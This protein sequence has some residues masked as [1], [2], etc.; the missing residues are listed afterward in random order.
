M[1]RDAWQH[2]VSKASWLETPSVAKLA[3][4]TPE[5]PTKLALAH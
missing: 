1:A 3:T 2:R 4:V 5:G